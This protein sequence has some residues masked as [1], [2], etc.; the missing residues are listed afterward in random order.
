MWTTIPG[1]G[2]RRGDGDLLAANFSRRLDIA[3]KF[4]KPKRQ[5]MLASWGDGKHK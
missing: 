1:R 2:K 5:H 3:L 4:A